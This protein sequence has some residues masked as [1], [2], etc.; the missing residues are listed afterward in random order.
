MR[1]HSRG[2]FFARALHHL[3]PSRKQRGRREDRVTAAPGALAPEKLREGRVTTGTGGNTPA[4]PAQWFTTYSVLSSVNQRLPPSLSRDLW[5]LAKT[6]RLHGRARTTRLR[7]P[8]LCRSSVGTAASTASPPHVRDVRDR[9]SSS[10][11]DARKHGI[12]LPDGAS[13]SSCGR[14][15]RRAITQIVTQA[16]ASGG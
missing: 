11:R 6:W 4:F 5:S 13:G 2:A 3:R 12:D 16:I 7:R 14:L 10:R 9:P 1:P 15:A 8:R